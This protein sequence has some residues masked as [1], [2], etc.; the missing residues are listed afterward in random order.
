[1]G[2]VM[3]KLRLAGGDEA[4]SGREVFGDWAR[5]RQM[6]EVK[7]VV[8]GRERWSHNVTVLRNIYA[9]DNVDIIYSTPHVRRFLDIFSLSP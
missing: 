7:V 2:E 9:N 4:A 3:A 1:M 8:E 5:S 6:L